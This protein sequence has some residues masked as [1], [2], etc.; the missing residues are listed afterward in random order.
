VEDSVYLTLLAAASEKGACQAFNVG[1]GK[2]VSIN[3]LAMTIIEALKLREQ[4]KVSYVDYDNIRSK[5]IEIFNRLANMDKVVGLF[6]YLPSTTL[7]QG[8]KEYIDW[9]QKNGIPQ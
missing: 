5:E 1:T 3:T 8:I 6:Q 2:A 9:Y 7:G 4:V